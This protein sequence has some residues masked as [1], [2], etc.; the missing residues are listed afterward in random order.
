MK[1]L[2]YV[3]IIHMSSDMGSL[4]KD[5][6]T[7]G[8]ADLGEELWKEH[9]KTVGTFWDELSHYF[10]SITEGCLY[11]WYRSSGDGHI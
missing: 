7:R 4:A 5:L 6:N 8:I 11:N 9:I 3:P 2:I 10:N 1:A